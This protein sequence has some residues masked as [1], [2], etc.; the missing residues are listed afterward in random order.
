M[1]HRVTLQRRTVTNDSYGQPIETWSTVG[2]VWAEIKP[3]SG[4]QLETL[5]EQFEDITHQITLRYSAD[6]D[7]KDRLVYRDRYFE[8][9]HV[10]NFD[11]RDRELRV[12][13]VERKAN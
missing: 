9:L 13:A 10:I 5:A 2:D 3:L 7:A 6:I 12:M 4:R 1:R 11:E 8:V